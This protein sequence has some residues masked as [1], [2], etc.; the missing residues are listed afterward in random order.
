M[1]LTIDYEDYDYVGG[2]VMIVI[3]TIINDSVK[4]DDGD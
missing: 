4:N 1:M 2:E 3:I